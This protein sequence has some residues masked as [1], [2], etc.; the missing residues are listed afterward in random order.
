M[1]V[2]VKEPPTEIELSGEGAEQV[3][4][5]LKLLYHDRLVIDEDEETVDITQTEW[6]RRKAEEVTPGKRLR[7]YRE[8]RQFSLGVLS[9]LTG[10]AK[11]NLSQMESGKR[12]IGKL[13]A[14]RL[15]KALNC[16]YRSLL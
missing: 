10:I 8:N 14:Q 3:L 5:D 7:I 11:S 6:Y 12:P 13:V 15:A 4:A 9:E 1:L 2:R 16:D